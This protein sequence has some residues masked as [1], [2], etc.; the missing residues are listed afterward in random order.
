MERAVDFLGKKSGKDGDR[1]LLWRTDFSNRFTRMLYLTWQLYEDAKKAGADDP[2]EYMS[3]VDKLYGG[4]F[5][6]P[7]EDR[8]I[9][10]LSFQGIGGDGHLYMQ[11]KVVL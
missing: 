4:Q 7:P 9:T 1:T 3:A 11:I 5:A 8:R 6:P 10:N 2:S